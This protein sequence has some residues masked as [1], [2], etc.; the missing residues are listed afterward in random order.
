M[1]QFFMFFVNFFPVFCLI[2]L[3]LK[4]LIVDEGLIRDKITCYDHFMSYIFRY[5]K[6]EH[7]K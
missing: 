7:A 4:F 6:H 3:R 1:V 5:H 2:S